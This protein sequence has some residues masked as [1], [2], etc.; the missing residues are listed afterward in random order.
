MHICICFVLYFISM[1]IFD[2]LFKLTEEVLIFYLFL[3]ILGTKLVC[4]V[5]GVGKFWKFGNLKIKIE[6]PVSKLICMQIFDFLF[7]LPEELLIFYLFLDI[8]GTKL[9]TWRHRRGWIL[10]IWKFKVQN[11]IPR[12]K[13]NLYANFWL[14]IQTP[15]GINDILP[16]FGYFGD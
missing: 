6:F 2:F 8:L 4:D 12:V 1:Q 3:D 7:K 9:V 15:W 13:I 11:Q 5:T 14:F 16:I 10:I